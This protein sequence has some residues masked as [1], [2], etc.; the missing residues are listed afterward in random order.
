MSAAAAVELIIQRQ[1]LG[2][3]YTQ[4]TLTV[5]GRHVCY[6]L[7]DVVRA[8]GVKIFGETAI[9]PGRYRTLITWSPHFG[10][11]MP[12]LLGVPNFS[13]IRI[14]SGNSSADTEG[15]ILVGE[16]LGDGD[17]IFLSRDAAAEVQTIIEEG[18]RAN[19][20][21]WTVVSNPSS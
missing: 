10:R 3:A 16:K 19:K 4:G 13:G 9:P 1:K 5:D 12:E 18:I 7:E 21:V 20:E 2:Q 14:H 6:T 11:Y 15:C 17:W 8:P